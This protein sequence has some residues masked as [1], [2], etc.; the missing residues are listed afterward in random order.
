MLLCRSDLGFAYYLPQTRNARSSHML[1]SPAELLLLWHEANQTKQESGEHH[2][3]LH[4]RA[5][6]R[7]RHPKSAFTIC[8]KIVGESGYDQT[9][10]GGKWFRMLLP[11]CH[12]A[13]LPAAP[14]AEAA[15]LAQTLFYGRWGWF[16]SFALRG[17]TSRCWLLLSAE[18]CWLDLSNSTASLLV[19]SDQ[20][21]MELPAMGAMQCGPMGF[22]AVARQ[23]EINPV[24]QS[25]IFSL[26]RLMRW[27]FG[28][29]FSLCPPQSAKLFLRLRTDSLMNSNFSSKLRI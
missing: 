20:E 22:A 18:S 27:D 25:C 14:S 29:Y 3:V 13:W 7:I 21:K 11:H 17:G 24:W 10:V 26:S 28:M 19:L 23:R 1:E 16:A 6:W 4:W 5:I 9:V 8:S 15:W 12:C 2:A